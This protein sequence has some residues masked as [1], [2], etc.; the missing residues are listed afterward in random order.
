M[1]GGDRAS[2]N[3]RMVPETGGVTYLLTGL[4]WS[5]LGRPGQGGSGWP[6]QY[7]F[8]GAGGGCLA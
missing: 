8:G 3:T 7:D 4:D 5:L 2:R 1:G 6:A